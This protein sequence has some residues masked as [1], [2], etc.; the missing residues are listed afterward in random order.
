[1]AGKVKETKLDQKK[2]TIKKDSI[3]KVNLDKQKDDIEK[4]KSK[5]TPLLIVRKSFNNYPSCFS[6][7]TR[8][9]HKS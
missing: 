3:K 2:D 8:N 6:C 7:K 5:K 1:M 9:T 4:S